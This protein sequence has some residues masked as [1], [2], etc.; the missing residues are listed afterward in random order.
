MEHAGDAGPSSDTGCAGYFLTKTP[1]DMVHQVNVTP[2][3]FKECVGKALTDGAKIA[4]RCSLKR[5]HKC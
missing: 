1:K 5:I 2:T 4:N 3:I